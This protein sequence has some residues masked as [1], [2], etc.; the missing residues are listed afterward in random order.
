[1]DYATS[2]EMERWLWVTI[3][4]QVLSRR[5]PGRCLFYDAESI[6][7]YATSMV[8]VLVSCKGI[9]KELSGENYENCLHSQSLSWDS[10]FVPF[11][12]ISVWSCVRKKMN[13]P[14]K[15][16]GIQSQ[17]FLNTTASPLSFPYYLTTLST[18]TITY[19]LW[20][21]SENGQL[22]E[23]YCEGK[24]EKAVGFDSY[25]YYWEYN[26]S[27]A[28]WICSESMDVIPQKLDNLD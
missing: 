2:N 7:V 25:R 22:A 21:A 27:I 24:P 16:T 4:L 17:H 13:K 15:P 8:R 20:F 9:W 26:V 5:R 18:A 12:G 19:H 3:Y 6:S 10:K 28:H 14:S 1:M 23:W 11:K